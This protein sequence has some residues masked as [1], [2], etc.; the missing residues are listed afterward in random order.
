MDYKEVGMRSPIDFFNIKLNE[1]ISEYRAKYKPFDEPCARLE[2]RDK[3]E[4]AERES[5]RRYGYVKEEEIRV[6]IGNLDKYG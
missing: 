3:L 4:N 1:K 5:E 2:F 6:E